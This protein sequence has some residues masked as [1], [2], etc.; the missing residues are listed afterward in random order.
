MSSRRRPLVLIVDDCDCVR[1]VL[2][3]VLQDMAGIRT[4]ER[5]HPKKH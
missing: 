2:K 4:V 3:V 1:V 5:R